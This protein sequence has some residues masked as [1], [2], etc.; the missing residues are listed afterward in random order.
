MSLLLKHARAEMTFIPGGTFAMGSDQHY[1]EE[2]PV[3]RVTDDGFWM[4]P[5]PVTQSAAPPVRRGDRLRCVRRDCAD[6][7]GAAFAWGDE[8]T[9]GEHMPNTWQGDFPHEK[10]SGRMT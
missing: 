7:K 1:P 4:D 2:T 10:P 6:G 9:P 5:T 8:F 3:H